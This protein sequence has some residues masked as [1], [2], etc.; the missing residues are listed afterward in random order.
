MFS[1]RCY[2]KLDLAKILNENHGNDSNVLNQ[3]LS[4]RYEHECGRV[5]EIFNVNP[6]LEFTFKIKLFE[7]YEVNKSIA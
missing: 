4:M 6:S 7:L 5:D 1:K 2:S 3:I